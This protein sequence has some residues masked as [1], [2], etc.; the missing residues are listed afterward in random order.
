MHSEDLLVDDG[1]DRQAVKAVGECLPQLDVVPTLAL[2]VEAVDT[3]DGG[4]LVVAPQDEKVLGVLDLVG[5]KQADGL[6]RLLATI[7]VVAKEEIVGL[8]RET[9]VLE[10]AEQVII[11]PMNIAANL[12]ERISAMKIK[13]ERG[14]ARTA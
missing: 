8:W 1:S 3:V 7:Y 14:H 9:A 4:A 6:E 5:E 2:V 10:Q 13:G 12:G 11:L